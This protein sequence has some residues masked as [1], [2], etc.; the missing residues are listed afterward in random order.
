MYKDRLANWAPDAISVRIVGVSR[1]N[2]YNG[3]LF[4]CE[5]VWILKKKKMIYVCV[6]ASV[7]KIFSIHTNMGLL[8][9]SQ[10]EYFVLSVYTFLVWQ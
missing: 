6:V 4:P 3:I 1:I 7:L 2:T 9:I 5:M 8:E 10:I